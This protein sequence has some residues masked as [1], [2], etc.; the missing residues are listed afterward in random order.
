MKALSLRNVCIVA[1]FC[2]GVALGAQVEEKVDEKTTS[3]PSETPEKFTP[4]NVDF[5]YVRREEMVPMRDGV[6]LKT[7]ILIPKGA[8]NAPILLN[9]TPYDAGN[10]V[11][12]ANSPHLIAAVPQMDDTAV[13]AGYII[14]FQDVR[15]KYGSEGDYVMTRALRGPANPTQVDHAT[16]CYDTIEWLVKNVPESNGRVAT[17]GGSYEGYTTVMS[18]VRPHPAL[19]AAVPFAPM[20]D[21]WM[22]DDWFH[23]G[24]FRQLGSLEY[25]YDQEA[26]RKG[27]AKWWYGEYDAYDTFLRA[28]SAGALA[29]A[30]GLDQ[31]GFWHALAE[32]TSYDWWWQAQAVDKVLAKEPLTVPMMIV[33]GLFDQEDIYGGPALFRALASKDPNGEKLHLVLGPWNHG[34]GRREGRA[35]AAIQFEGD[36]AGWFRRTVMQPFLD[37]YL[38]DAP[39]PATPRVLV[40]ETG[41]NEWRRYHDW[42]QVCSEGCAKKSRSLYLLPGGKLG[43]DAPAAGAERYDEYISDPAKP[44]TYRE[45]PT[46]AQGAENSGWGDWLVDDQRFAASRTDVLVYQTEPLREPVRLAGEPIARLFASTSG[47]DSD[48]V[49]KIIDVWPDEV[50]ERPTMGGYQQMLSA[51]IFRG[52]YRAD[53]SK[54]QPLTPNKALEYR[55]RLPHA[56]HTFLPGHRIMVQIQSSWFPLYDRNPQTF[57]P[58]IM[59]ADPRTYVKATQ[60]V[61]HVPGTASAIELPVE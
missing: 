4:T 10:R 51:D 12:R 38:K 45:R 15:G 2:C 59:F 16:D 49:V 28:G 30:R 58:N 57:V 8:K 44:V 7:F 39:K 25:T 26:T 1:M 52:R 35:L 6:K 37:H 36:T 23:N 5:D 54:P 32:H 22:G 17:L 34:Q 56:S 33:S 21:G 61:W 27:D 19:K 11:L 48:W 9:R 29:K 18:T 14:A 40:Y 42:P 3:L 53:F 50:Q 24:A 41:A 46:L 13:Q 47:T 43:F 60:R 55:I 31:L 20:V